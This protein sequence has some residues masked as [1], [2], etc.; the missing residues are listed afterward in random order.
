M[1]L[2]SRL[3][4]FLTLACVMLA[5]T[6]CERI[7]PVRTLPSWVRGIYVPIAMN[8]TTEPGLEE[9]LTREIQHQFLADGRVDIVKKGEADLQLVTVIKSYSV[10]ID[11]VDSDDIARRHKVFILADVLLFDPTVDPYNTDERPIAK[12]RE[13]NTEFL[14]NADP[15]STNYII[16]PDAREGAMGMLARQV[17]FETI[18]GFPTELT[19]QDPSNKLPQLKAPDRGLQGDVFR[20]K[21]SPGD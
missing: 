11:D 5:A 19:G 14:M 17:V 15:R 4:L 20:N 7:R 1:R 2:F 12:L 13:L 8:K 3:F 6:S 10:M 9:V 21:R 18:N 16:E